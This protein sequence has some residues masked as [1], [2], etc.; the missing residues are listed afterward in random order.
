MPDTA[1]GSLVRQGEI[2]AIGSELLLGGRVDSNSLFLMEGLAR[3]GVELRFK[4]VVGDDEDDIVAALETAARRA[5]VVLLTGGLGPTSDDRTRQAVA[6]A[7]GSP[8]RRHAQAILGM[9]RQLA[10]WG[11][12]PTR[13]Q[14]RQGLIPA[15]AEVLDNP[16]GSA[17][18]FVLRWKGAL[19][20]ALPG[21]PKEAEQM[22]DTALLPRLLAESMAGGAEHLHRRIIQTFGLP[23]SEVDQRIGGLIPAGGAI[24]LGLLASPLGVLVSL[25]AWS[26]DSDPSGKR[27]KKQTGMGQLD[28]VVR[29]VRTRLGS[30]VYAEGDDTMEQVVGRYLKDRDL[31][32]AVAESCTGGL[33]GHRLTQI[34]GSSAYLDRVA[35]CYSNQAKTEWLGVPVGM[36]KRHGAVS[37]QVAAAMARGVRTRSKTSIGLSVTGIAGPGGGTKD[38]PVGLVYI[39][40]DAV[41]K[42]GKSCRITQ[43]FQFH[44][45]RETIKLRASQAALNMLRQWLIKGGA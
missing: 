3:A 23:E 8:L 27:A 21:V 43:A 40:L 12:K 17:P 26:K 15:G 42:R 31:T 45:N 11:R 10:L 22:F 35:V 34:A 13:A 14:L 16:V 41:P 25:T 18:G 1:G 38:K 9:R 33:I 32:L 29:A 20:A 44:G 6:R 28:R 30:S 2:I 5:D 4:A 19:I 24:K 36:L 39:G 37:S 7:V